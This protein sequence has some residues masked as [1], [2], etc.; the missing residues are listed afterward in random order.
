MEFY[1][2]HMIEIIQ[3]LQK[4]DFLDDGHYVIIVILVLYDFHGNQIIDVVIE[5][6][7]DFAEPAFAQ[8]F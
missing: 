3:F 5:S 2:R 1:K 8:L 6:F 4:I 7:I